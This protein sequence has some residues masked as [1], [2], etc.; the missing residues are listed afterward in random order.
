M[1]HAV[2][3]KLTIHPP[4]PDF[5]ELPWNLPL[6]KWAGV[7]SRL[8]EVDQGISRHPVLYVNFDGSLYALKEMPT[9]IAEVE[10][11]HLSV[12]QEL[13]LPA[14]SPIG[15]AE[16][17]TSDG[18]ASVL[19]TRYLNHSIPYRTLFMRDSLN[20]Y[21]EYLLDAIAGLL[22]QIH[23]AGVY[24][25]DCSLSNTLFRR[26]A[27]ELKAYLV[28][29]ETSEIHLDDLQPALRHEDLVIMEENIN[30]ELADLVAADLAPKEVPTI[31][32]GAYIRLRYQRLWE[33]VTRE[34]IVNP[35][36]Y[37]RIQERIRA[38]NKLG[39]SI[40]DVELHPTSSGNQLRLSIKVADRSF[41]HNQLL[42]LTG[43]DAEERQARQMMNEVQEF[44][45]K[46]SQEK[47][48][49]TPLS[50]AAFNWLNTIYQP[51]INQITASI[52]SKLSSPELYCQVLEHKWLLS[53]RACHDV[54][55]STATDDYIKNYAGYN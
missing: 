48:R 45:A 13:S 35:G 12:I 49:S 27:G 25:G 4:N 22:V 40:G 44:K 42:T 2:A 7:C 30:G 17:Q 51:T 21:H 54:G 39:F 33:E 5:L 52:D 24:W 41:H 36:E 29:A 37:Y 14:I 19:I 1:Q 16:T 8:E 31:D 26:D 6:T 53:E 15:Y 10:Y 3:P 28:D 38:L 23:L 18:P 46:L 55:H 43:I 34:D 50:V 47:K 20:R 32:T 9:A 11:N